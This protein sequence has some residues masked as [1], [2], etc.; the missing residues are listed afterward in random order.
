MRMMYYSAMTQA[1]SEK[2]ELK[3]D[4]FQKTLCKSG[5][6]QESGIYTVYSS[7]TQFWSSPSILKADPKIYLG[8]KT[9]FSSNANAKHIYALKNIYI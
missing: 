5:R 1:N 2:D 8:P 7:K 3:L 4:S 6:W 9:I